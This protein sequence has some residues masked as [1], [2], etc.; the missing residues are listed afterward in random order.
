MGVCYDGPVADDIIAFNRKISKLMLEQ[1]KFH[2]IGFATDDLAGTKTLFIKMGY[3]PGEEVIV[4]LQKVKVCFLNKPGHPQIELI[5]SADI[6]SP[7]DNILKKCGAGPYHFCYSVNDINDALE[8][9][10]R[11]KFIIL[12]KPVKSNAIDDHCIIFAFRKNY[13]LIE[14]VE[15]AE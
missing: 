14:V 7:I 2:H 10:K 8:S 9:L 3:I 15:I 4:P 12:N 11:E 13:G 1:F 5:T 6:T